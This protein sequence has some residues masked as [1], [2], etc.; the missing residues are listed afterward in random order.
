MSWM[1]DL[2]DRDVTQV[3]LA[4]GLRLVR[5]ALTPCPKCG[6]ASRGST[7]P[8]GPVGV[9]ADKRGWKCHRCKETGDAI[10]LV[11]WVFLGHGQPAPN[12]WRQFEA[13]VARRGLASAAAAPPTATV[14]PPRIDPAE[15]KAFWDRCLPA[16]ADDAVREW[17]LNRNLPLAE[18]VSRDLARVVPASGALPW[19][20]S[21]RG[22]KW[23]Q[24]QQQFRVVVQLFDARGRFANVHARALNP[25][26][27]KGRDKA[28]AT[29]L[30]AGSLKGLAMADALGRLMLA[31]GLVGDGRRARDV[32]KDAHL[33]VTEGEPDFLT[34][35]TRY[36]ESN[37]Q[38]RAVLGVV[39]GSW[40][41]E[42][43]D[44]V[45]FHTHVCVVTHHDPDGD[46]YAESI[47]SS[48]FERCPVYRRPRKE[49]PNARQSA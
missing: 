13:E 23:N 2:K 12:E 49:L 47:R 17:M 44:C 6:A 9:R 10:N 48:L 30:G 21:W 16:D 15:L 41:K 37:E 33:V 38:A 46:G 5:D 8:R 27:P 3:G 39:A 43:A 29:A 11:S 36:S 35:A 25:Q 19:W 40:T 31:D 14:P 22:E 34:W 20:A 42:I 4:L 45:P 32:V 7:D 1:D 26:D 18:V 24:C 28:A